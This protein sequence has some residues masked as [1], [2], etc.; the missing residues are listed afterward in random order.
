[1]AWGL[2]QNFRTGWASRSSPRRIRR[3]CSCT[4]PSGGRVDLKAEYQ[5]L[6]KQVSARCKG[7]RR[8]HGA[9]RPGRP[10]LSSVDD[11][12]PSSCRRGYTSR[13]WRLVDA[14]IP[15]TGSSPATRPSI[16]FAKG[17]R[18]SC[19]STRRS[20]TRSPSS[21]SRPRTWIKRRAPRATRTTAQLPPLDRGF[22]ETP[23]RFGALVAALLEGGGPR[24]LRQ[25]VWWGSEE[26]G[27]CGYKLRT[28]VCLFP[29][30]GVAGDAVAFRPRSL[31]DFKLL[32]P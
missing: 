28:C 11:T 12:R 6:D 9:L 5:G 20:S 21:A 14:E 27:A 24:V 22:P 1:M 19:P 29:Y 30:D 15:H 8:D 2:T 17:T 13:R 26:R 3:A 18:R 4:A 32:A 31:A 23:I 25:V 7:G 16:C 10:V